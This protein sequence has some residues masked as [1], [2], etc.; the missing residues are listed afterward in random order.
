MKETEIDCNKYRTHTHLAGVDVQAIILEKGKCELTIK[1]AYYQKSV[2][3]N[4]KNKDAY[5][6]SFVETGVKDMI[7]NSTNRK[8]ITKICESFKGLTTPE[9]RIISRW[10]GLKIELTFDPTVVMM[11][12]VVGGI[13]VV[14]T[15]KPELK[16]DTE[17]FTACVEALKTGG[18]SIDQIKTKY[19]L[20]KE[21]EALLLEACKK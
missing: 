19:I 12:K 8:T 17:K 15:L 14:E 7:V 4:G 1:E 21:I 18:Y 9:A 10:N 3:V 11:S 6:L 5:F 20:S 2:N 13:R 16:K